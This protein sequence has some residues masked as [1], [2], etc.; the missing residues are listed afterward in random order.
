MTGLA[1]PQTKASLLLGI[2]VANRGFNA[3][4]SNFFFLT[5]KY[6][7]LKFLFHASNINFCFKHF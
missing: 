4:L 6:Y 7:F 3:V 5:L 1:K 2:H